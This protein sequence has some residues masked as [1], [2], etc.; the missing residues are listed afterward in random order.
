M[1]NS[2]AFP[3]LPLSLLHL[4]LLPHS[5]P[6]LMSLLVQMA[7]VTGMNSAGGGWLFQ[8]YYV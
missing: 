3:F 1:L 5:H 2:L 6:H 4:S 8:L 7:N